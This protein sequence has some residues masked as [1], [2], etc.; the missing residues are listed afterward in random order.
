LPYAAAPLYAGF[1]TMA[2]MLLR[3]HTPFPVRVGTPASF[4]GHPKP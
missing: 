3:L 1:L 4:R 2:A